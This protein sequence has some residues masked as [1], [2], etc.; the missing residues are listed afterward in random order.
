VQFA[1][2]P[3]EVICCIHDR[4]NETTN[5][6]IDLDRFKSGDKVQI[7]EGAFKGCSAIFKSYN[8]DERLVL[9]MNLI[10]QTQKLV[11]PKKSIVAA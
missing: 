4:L 11:M 9:L 5:K 1:K 7:T 10:G 2:V 6:Y 8:S 3:D